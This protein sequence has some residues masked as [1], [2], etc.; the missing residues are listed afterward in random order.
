MLFRSQDQIISFAKNNNRKIVTLE[1]HQTVGGLG[2]LT[3]E[4]LSEHYPSQVIRVGVQNRFGQ[5]GNSAQ[6]YREYNLDREHIKEKIRELV[7][8]HL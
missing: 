6:L 8:K 5:S 7:S 2:S 4:I 1:E 3:S